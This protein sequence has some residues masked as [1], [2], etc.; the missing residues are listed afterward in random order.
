M[1]MTGT[2][3]RPGGARRGFTLVEVLIAA[4]V[5]VVV[6]VPLIGLLTN[7][8]TDQQ[9]EEGMSEAVAFCQE[10]MEKLISNNLPFEAIDPGA[11]GSFTPAIGGTPQAGFKDATV[12]GQTFTQAQLEKLVNDEP[13]GKDRVRKVKGKKYLVYFFAG[14]YPDG[15]PVDDSHEAPFKRADID[16]TLTF[17]YLEKPAGYGQPY[18]FRDADRTKYNRQTILRD[19]PVSLANIESSPYA[20]RS[21]LVAGGANPTA[22]LV[23]NRKREYFYRDLSRIFP[24]KP[25]QTLISG[26]PDPN[27]TPE[28]YTGSFSFDLNAGDGLQRTEWAAHLRA[29]AARGKKPSIGYHPV[30][31]DQ[32]T[33]KETN[34][35]LM[36][37]ILGVKFSPYEHSHLRK[38]TGDNMRE[39]WLASFKANL[40][41]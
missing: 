32:R 13:G 19:T 30:T 2:R 31:I 21:Y 36:K 20:L 16:K 12:R 37:I 18:N 11:G 33:F 23:D 28:G 38:D 6:I 35:A 17:S 5:L 7:Q 25:G 1:G 15:P 41:D 9:S 27:D 29:V 34:G 8:K 4:L 14:R 26:W 22:E 24:D 3:S 40:E 39:F 10:M